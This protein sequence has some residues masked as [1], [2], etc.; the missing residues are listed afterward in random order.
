M[1]A[2]FRLCE[3]SYKIGIYDFLAEQDQLEKELCILLKRTSEEAEAKK[4]AD[5]FCNEARKLSHISFTYS[6]Q[7]GKRQYIL[8]GP[9]EDVNRITADFYQKD[10]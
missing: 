5:F 7:S 2:L 10:F 8:K 3:Q 4:I 9:E 6:Y 1:L